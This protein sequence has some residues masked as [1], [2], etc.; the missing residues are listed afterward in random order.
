MYSYIRTSQTRSL[1]VIFSI[2]RIQSIQASIKVYKLNILYGKQDSAVGMATACGFDDRGVEVRVPV[3]S[4][5][6]SSPSR[7]DLF[8]SPH[9]FLSIRKGFGRWGGGETGPGSK[10]AGT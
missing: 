1:T 10:A 3:G 7:R 9:S 5:I 2:G 4:R 8:R 6:F